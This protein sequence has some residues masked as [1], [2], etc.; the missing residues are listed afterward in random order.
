MKVIFC[1]EREMFEEN[2]KGVV[3]VM[4]EGDS[5]KLKKVKR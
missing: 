4:K 1:N 3:V 2:G 5:L